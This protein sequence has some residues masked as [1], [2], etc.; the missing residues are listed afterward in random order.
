MFLNVNK[1]HVVDLFLIVQINRSLTST[2][3]LRSICKTSLLQSKIPS[4]INHN[5]QKVTLN[6]C[7]T[8][9]CLRHIINAYLSNFIIDTK[10]DIYI[11]CTYETLSNLT[12]ILSS[13]QNIFRQVTLQECKQSI[14][15]VNK[16]YHPP[17]FIKLKQYSAIFSTGNFPQIKGD[18]SYFTSR[19]HLNA[20]C[21]CLRTAYCTYIFYLQVTYFELNQ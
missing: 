10:I 21:N 5:T 18:Y 7:H 9:V 20:I 16:H 19:N 15:Q 4:K 8:S 2:H 13:K 3:D 11:T 14:S 1:V 6:S 12:E 17:W